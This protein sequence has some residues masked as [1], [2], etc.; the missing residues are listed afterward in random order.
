MDEDGKVNGIMYQEG[1]PLVDEGD[2]TFS[3]FCDDSSESGEFILLDEFKKQTNVDVDLKIYPYET[4]TVSF[5]A[6]AADAAEALFA[7]LLPLSLPHPVNMV[8]LIIVNTISDKL[9]GNSLW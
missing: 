8:M 2:Y 9:S 3:I 4:A 5:A 6:D 7:E 1:L